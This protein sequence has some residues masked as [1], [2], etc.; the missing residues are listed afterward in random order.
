MEKIARREKKLF[1]HY[2]G[3]KI[4]KLVFTR[5]KITPEE[6]SICYIGFRFLRFLIKHL[7]FYIKKQIA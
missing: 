3:G 2:S 1:R 4:D 6:K 7:L 5:G